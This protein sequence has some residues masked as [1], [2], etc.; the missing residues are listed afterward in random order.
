MSHD[1]KGKDFKIIVNMTEHNVSSEVMT[2][3]Q[4]TQI[5]FPGHPTDGQRLVPRGLRAR[6]EQAPRGYA[7]GRRKVTIKNH[8]SFDV[9]QTNRS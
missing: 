3:E 4:V 2:Y 6:G 9:T 1:D 7:G 8:T 5:A